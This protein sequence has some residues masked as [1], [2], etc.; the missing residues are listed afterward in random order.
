MNL[1]DEQLKYIQKYYK[2][3]PVNKISEKLNISIKTTYL[4]I[5]GLFG[6]TVPNFSII[7]RETIEKAYRALSLS[8]FALLMIFS[9]EINFSAN[10]AIIIFVIF[11]LNFILILCSLNIV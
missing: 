3:I 7:Y 5:E 8:T 1:S 4:A 10:L 6:D 9:I 11:A 2:Q